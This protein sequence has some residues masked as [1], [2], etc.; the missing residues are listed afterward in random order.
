MKERD[1]EAVKNVLLGGSPRPEKHIRVLDASDERQYM[2]NDNYEVY[3]KQGAPLGALSF[4]YHN[5]YEILYVLEGE[6]AAMMENQTY[7]LKKGDFLLVDINVL[8]KYH[9]MEQKHDSS[10]RIILWVT[11]QMLKQLSGEGL[12]LAACFSGGRAGARDGYR[13]CA[14]HFPVYYEEMLRG[15]LLKLAMSEVAGDG[16]P[17]AKEMLDRGYLTLF[18]AHL[19]IL[20]SHKEY[21]FA[22]ED[23]VT[24]P[25]VEQVSSYVEAHIGE[26]VTVEQLAGQVHISKYYFLR[27]FKELTGVTVHAFVTQKR[28]IRA[29][30]EIISGKNIT[31]VYQDCGFADYSSFLRNFKA[32]FGVSP[33]KYSELL[34]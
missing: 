21:L 29:C 14:W 12:D 15:Y 18:F 3:E 27:K 7:Y 11:S 1:V 31:Q 16:L 26:R 22:R 2:L 23:T 8:H 34:Q 5:F 4:H 13:T 25:L 30:E 17:G 32:A 10:R 33:G 19:N 6:Y 24:H 28:L 20:C 9:F